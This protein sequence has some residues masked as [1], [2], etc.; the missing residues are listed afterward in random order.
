MQGNPINY[1]NDRLKT[2]AMNGIVA[3][4]YLL[5]CLLADDITNLNCLIC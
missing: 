1:P 4:N 2:L 5:G 3:T